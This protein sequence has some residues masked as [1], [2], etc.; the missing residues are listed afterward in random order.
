VIAFCSDATFAAVAAMPDLS[1][2]V[3]NSSHSC[4][5]KGRAE[6][7]IMKS[8]LML[9]IA[10]LM[11]GSAADASAGEGPDSGRSRVVRDWTVFGFRYVRIA[12]PHRHCVI[13]DV[14]STDYYA[15]G[16]WTGQPK[17]QC[18]CR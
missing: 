5:T 10:T 15:Y 8:L 12:P 13:P 17:T 1:F 11:L 18:V 9:C 4:C 14:C 2:A 6:E 3:T 16:H 7:W